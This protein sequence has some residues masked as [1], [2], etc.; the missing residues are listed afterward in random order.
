MEE[1]G[2]VDVDMEND[3]YVQEEIE[4][5]T[6]DPSWTPEEAQEAYD[7]CGDDQY[8]ADKKPKYH[9]IWCLYNLDLFIYSF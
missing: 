1:E 6:D 9:S 4:S 2:D 7:D 3:L 8:T 5:D